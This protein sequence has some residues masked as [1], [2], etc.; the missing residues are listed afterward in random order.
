MA[1]A[2]SAKVSDNVPPI[3]TI[4]SPTP[5]SFLTSILR[6]P[7]TIQ[8]SGN[9]SD[10][11]IREYR[12]R[13]FVGTNPDFPYVPDFPVFL[14]SNPDSVLR[15]Y[16][17]KFSGWERLRVEKDSAVASVTYSNLFQ[18]HTYMFVVV[19][20]DNEGAWDANLSRDRNM[21]QFQIV[22]N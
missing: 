11:R 10:G 1:G 17:P 6:P 20:I 4:L 21:L 18:S 7:V 19:S 12:Y 13:L 5:S 14:A 16:A 22:P 2:V 9:D 15:F 3:T 8:W